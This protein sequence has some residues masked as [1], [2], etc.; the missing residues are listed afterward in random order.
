MHLF[1]YGTLMYPALMEEFSGCKLPRV[2]ATLRGYTRRAV[3]GASYP[4]IFP[5]AGGSVQGCLYRDL[6]DS[7]WAPLDRFE[8]EMYARE[9]VRVVLEDDTSLLA[10]VYAVRPEFYHCLDT[11][12]WDYA[13]FLA[14]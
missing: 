6:P 7:S 9:Q 12:D 10:E 4:G 14:R 1:V 5:D 3:L 8:G 11:S 2:P 13:A